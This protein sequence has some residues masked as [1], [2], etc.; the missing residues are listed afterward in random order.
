MGQLP[1][2]SDILLIQMLYYISTVLLLSLSHLSDN[3]YYIYSYIYIYIYIYTHTHIQCMSSI[4][5]IYIYI[6]IYV[7][8]HTQYMTSIIYTYTH[9]VCQYILWYCSTFSCIKYWKDFAD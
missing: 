7:Y 3:S 4:I 6:Y 8:T 9:N 1:N 2:C 5:Y